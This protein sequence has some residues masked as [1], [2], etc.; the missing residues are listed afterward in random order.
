M[1]MPEPYVHISAARKV[2]EADMD[3]EAKRFAVMDLLNKAMDALDEYKGSDFDIVR[4]VVC[5]QVGD[6]QRMCD[7]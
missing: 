3:S 2:A 6:L 4:A 7:I 5:K 1:G